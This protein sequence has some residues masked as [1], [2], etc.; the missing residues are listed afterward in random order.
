MHGVASCTKTSQWWVFLHAIALWAHGFII[1]TQNALA[2]FILSISTEVI[3]VCL[4]DLL[5]YSGNLKGYEAHLM[6]VLTTLRWENLC[7]KL[8]TCHLYKQVMY[9]GHTITIDDICLDLKKVQVVNEW[10]ILHIVT[11]WEVFFKLHFFFLV[12][13]PWLSML[14]IAILQQGG[15]K[16]IQPKKKLTH[17]M[18]GCS[19]WARI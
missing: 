6:I 13:H 19:K 16:E 9:W 18:D 14:S 17:S 8:C 1:W 15:E 3:I 10:L 5:T 11:E 2:T 4:D 7:A 12:F